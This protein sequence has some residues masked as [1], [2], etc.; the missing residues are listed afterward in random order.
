MSNY[1]RIKQQGGCYFFTVVTY[2]RRQ[3]LTDDFARQCLRE[4]IK[5]TRKNY[6]FQINAWVLLPDHLHCIW[7]LPSGDDDYSIRWNIIKTQFTRQ[8]KPYYHQISLM[9]S[10]KIKHRETTLWQRR[11]WEHTIRDQD[12]YDHHVNYINNNPVK[13]G[14]VKHPRDWLYSTYHLN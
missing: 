13:H 5:I 10:S 4:A 8:A 9:N 14:W 7:T 6:P 2:Q 11:F 3:F 1:I 12:D